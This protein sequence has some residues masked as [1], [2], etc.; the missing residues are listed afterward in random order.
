MET[1]LPTKR[2]KKKNKY[3][4]FEES[5]PESIPE[6]PLSKPNKIFKETCTII[7]Y[8][9]NSLLGQYVLNLNTSFGYR[10]TLIPN[11]Y[12]N[13]DDRTTPKPW[14]LEKNYL[15]EV[16]YSGDNDTYGQIQTMIR[17]RWMYPTF[18]HHFSFL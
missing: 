12:Y 17:C 5:R 15:W 9:F 14:K 6:P 4:L 8:K 13:N 11:P 18:F 2:D 10:L 7:N 16:T 3:I 1:V